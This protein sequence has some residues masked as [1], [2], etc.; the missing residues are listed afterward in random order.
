MLRSR[1]SGASLSA[2]LLN[3]KITNFFTKIDVMLKFAIVR[4]RVAKDTTFFIISV[5]AIGS[6]KSG[7]TNKL[8][9]LF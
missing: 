2:T 8:D 6:A 1:K 4:I 9:V 3:L 5:Y 7:F